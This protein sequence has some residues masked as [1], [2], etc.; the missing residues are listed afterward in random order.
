[1][2]LDAPNLG[3]YIVS[4]LFV[5]LTYREGSYLRYKSE[6]KSIF[7]IQEIVTL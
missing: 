2:S 1:M 6:E 7:K 4:K 5:G 3:H